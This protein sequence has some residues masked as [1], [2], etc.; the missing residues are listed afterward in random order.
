MAFF[1]P[2]TFVGVIIIDEQYRIGQGTDEVAYLTDLGV[3][4]TKLG[5]PLTFGAADLAFQGIEGGDGSGELTSADIFGDD[6]AAM[7]A[8]TVVV[9]AVAAL[10]PGHT[11]SSL[12]EMSWKIG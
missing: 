1:P 7:A 6:V 11:M 4:G 5:T 12:S 9:A 10:F 2:L 8:F 3:E